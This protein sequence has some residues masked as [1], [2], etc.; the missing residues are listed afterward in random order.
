MIPISALEYLKIFSEMQIESIPGG[1]LFLYIEGDI[2]KWRMASTSFELEIFSVDEKIKNDSIA[3]KA[4]REKRVIKQTIPKSLYGSRFNT[5][6]IP[7]TENDEVK[8]AFSI[9]FPKVHPVIKSFPDFAP[10]MSKMFAEGVVMFVTDLNSIL[11][12]QA[13]KKFDIATLNKG[14][15]LEES[16]IASKA[17]SFGKIIM[18][19]LDSSVYG[20]DLF[21]VSYP[22]FDEENSEEVVATLTIMTPKELAANLRDMSNN[23]QN[24]LTGIAA[25]IEELAASASQIHVNEQELNKEIKII[26]NITEEINEIS[27]FIKDIA[28]ET[29][30]LGL[31][32]AIEAARAGEAGKGFGVVAEEIRKLS[33][34]SKS[35][36]PKINKLT[37][38]IKAKVEQVSEKSMSSL[39]SSQEQAS[40]T[41][42]ITASIE[43]IT[44]AA[45]ELNNIAQKL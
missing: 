21:E 42:E 39:S 35:T 29:K 11:Y 19:E 25:A 3:A 44:A 12:K 40:A 31:N 36:V 18:E 6:A 27:A 22:L 38:D 28:D 33:D 34:Q 32:A 9:L 23:L 17:I 8:G 26:T 43:E 4:M 7:I 30:M 45:E 37:Q 41:E 24:N 13:S 20:V 1:V 2:I 10:I 5:V 16:S 14:D 15:R